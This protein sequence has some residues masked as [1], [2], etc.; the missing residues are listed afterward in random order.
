MKWACRCTTAAPRIGSGRQ[1]Y[2]IRGMTTAGMS[3]PLESI[4]S[5]LAKRRRRTVDDFG[6][7]ARPLRPSQLGH[8]V[9]CH[10]RGLARELDMLDNDSGK[11]ADTGSAVHFAVAAYHRK[12]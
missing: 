10:W 9:L 5:S 8:L 3:V 7:A 11:A 12:E 2:P 1:Y 6:S 4:S